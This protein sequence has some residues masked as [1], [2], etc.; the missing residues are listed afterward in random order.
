MRSPSSRSPLA[1]GRSVTVCDCP[2]EAFPGARLRL[3]A[4]RSGFSLVYVWPSGKTGWRTW[5]TSRCA[6]SHLL[7][8][9]RA[10]RG[11]A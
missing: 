11:A 10:N 1:E 4:A 7:Y 8:A 6:M 3:E 2:S 5:I 9:V